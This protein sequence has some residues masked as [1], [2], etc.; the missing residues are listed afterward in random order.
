MT[1]RSTDRDHIPRQQILS[2]HLIPLP[3]PVDLE[4]LGRRLQ[5]SYLFQL[6]DALEDKGRLEDHQH[7]Q[8]EDRVVP[9]IFLLSG[10][11]RHVETTAHSQYFLINI[12]RAPSFP[13]ADDCRVS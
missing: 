12:C 2:S 7:H 5:A 4:G 10:L 8:G 13:G 9:A 1:C 6:A 3:K 11:L